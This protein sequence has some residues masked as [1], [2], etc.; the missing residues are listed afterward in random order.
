MLKGKSLVSENICEIPLGLFKPLYI[1][2]KL[3]A[4]FGL[5]TSNKAVN[6]T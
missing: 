3:C 5:K 4:S 1:A 6:K 2:S